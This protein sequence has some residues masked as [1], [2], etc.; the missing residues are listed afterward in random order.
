M[1]KIGIM[2]ALVKG[3]VC[4]IGGALGVYF[5]YYAVAFFFFYFNNPV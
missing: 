2:R 1:D 5:T 4:L 3:I